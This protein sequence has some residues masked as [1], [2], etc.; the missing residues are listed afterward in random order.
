[1]IGPG[2][3]ASP[4]RSADHPQAPC[5]HRTIERS[6][7]PND[8]EKKMATSD[9]AVKLRERN[10]DGWMSGV[11]LR[12]QWST[13]SAM[14]AADRGECPGDGGRA[15]APVAAL[16]EPEG[17]GRHAR[18]DQHDPERVGPFAGVTGHMRQSAPADDE[19]G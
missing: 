15:P 12:R 11:R 19:G 18:G 17:E 10:S 6:I 4:D 8:A 13:K 14:S 9:A 5:S 3:M 7:A 16:H 2:A 1:M